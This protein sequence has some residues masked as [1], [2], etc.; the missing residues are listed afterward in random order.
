MSVLLVTHGS[1]LDHRTP[2]GHPERVDRLAAVVEGVRSADVSIVDLGAPVVERDLLETIHTRSYI[3]QVHMFCVNG[4]GGLDQDTYVVPESFN[5]ALHA[6]GAGPAAVDA[7]EAGTADAAFVVVRPP[8]HHA[9]RSSAMGFC[10]FNNVALT[11]AYLRSRGE[12]VAIID[13]DVHHG[14]GT[15]GTFYRDPDVL[16]VSLHEFPLYPGSGWVDE[17]GEGPG[18]GRTINVP[19]PGGTSGDS[20]L[21]AFGRIVVPVVGQFDPDW[22]LISCGYDAHRLDPL[23]GLRLEAEHFGSMARW[24]VDQVPPARVIATLEGGYDLGAL[25]ESSRATVGGLA[26][27]VGEPSWPTELAGSAKRVT[28]LAVEAL[29][30]HWELR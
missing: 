2:P 6:A 25:T 29:E 26:G 9:E 27:V 10:L 18:A 21:A 8:G 17:R 16:Y 20:Y 23:G 5:A 1:S 12:R 3:D 22:I 30:T 11:A 7:L 4:G 13:W 24:A 19:L 14:N 28:E 15:Q